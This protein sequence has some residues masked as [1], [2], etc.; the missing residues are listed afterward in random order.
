MPAARD[1]ALHGLRGPVW[2]VETQKETHQQNPDCFCWELMVWLG[3]RPRRLAGCCG[4][5]GVLPSAALKCR[6]MEQRW[7]GAQLGGGSRVG[8]PTFSLGWQP[9]HLLQGSLC[10]SLILSPRL[11]ARGH[12]TGRLLSSGQGS[13]V[14]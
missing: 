3:C 6:P 2:K 11:L 7:V 8:A 1:P 12:R 9:R 10:S 14:L 4:A 13:F 5:W